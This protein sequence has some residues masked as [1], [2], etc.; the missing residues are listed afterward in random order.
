[1][2][3]RLTSLFD[4]RLADTLKVVLPNSVVLAMVNLASLNQIAQL[5][6]VGLTI[7]YTIWR[8][9]RDSYVVCQRCRDGQPPANCP[10]PRHKRPYWCPANL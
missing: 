1:M 6:A 2:V 10:Y 8:W 7:S 5:A 3:D 9:R 4:G